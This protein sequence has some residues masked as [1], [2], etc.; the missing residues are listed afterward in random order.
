MASYKELTAEQML[1]FLLAPIKYSYSSSIESRKQLVRDRHAAVKHA[2]PFMTD[3][4]RGLA[5]KWM[6]EESHSG[7]WD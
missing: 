5:D 6:I 2:Y 4:Q 7:L 3:E 1:S